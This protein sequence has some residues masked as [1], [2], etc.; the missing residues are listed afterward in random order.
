MF[1]E[2][3]VRP[4]REELTRVG[5]QEL[6][7]P[8]EVDAFLDGARDGTALIAVNST[9]GC[10]AGSMRPA[11]AAALRDGPQPDALGTV[12][13]GADAEA[14]AR[15]REHFAPYPPSSPAVALF[16]HGE[17]VFIL[18]RKDIQGR[19]PQEIAH[20]LRGA[21]ERYVAAPAD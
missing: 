7:T 12:F 17:L 2:M 4:M 20:D 13:A 21:L 3:I 5:L 9:C 8:Q 10:A 6:R 15:A 16:R 19:H 14:T 11:V 18:E 1:P